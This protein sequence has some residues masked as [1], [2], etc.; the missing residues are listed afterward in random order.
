M[1][2]YQKVS[3]FALRLA[4][5]WMFFYS[6]ITKVINPEWSAAG[7]L[8]NAK[9]F[10][11]LYQWFA[12]PGMLPVTNFLNEWGLTLVGASLILGVFVRLGSVFGIVLMLLYYFPRLQ[13]PYPDPNSFI[14]DSHIIYAFSLLVLAVF[15]AGNT[16][17]LAS[18]L[19]PR[20]KKWMS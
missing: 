8:N 12:Q 2:K 3:L 10:T 1:T 14:V 5:G 19:P 11:G 18:K 20:L 15:G 16:W 17:G 4:M 13:F 9:T 6:G 7:F